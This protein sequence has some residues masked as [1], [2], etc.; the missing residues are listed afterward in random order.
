MSGPDLAELEEILRHSFAS[1][2]LLEQ[3]LT[4]ASATTGACTDNE[5]IEFL[6]DAVVTLAVNDYLYRHYTQC[7]EGRLT[8]IKS[9]VVSA[10]S[11]AARARELGLGRFAHMGRGMPSGGELS[12]AVLA[13]LFEAVVGALYLDAGFDRAMDF[14]LDQ[15]LDEIEAV[16]L[17]GGERNYKAVL[18]K[19]ASA[20][21]GE[22]PHYRLVSQAGPDHEKVFEVEVAIGERAFPS[23]RGRTKKEAEQRAAGHALAVLREER[24][25]EGE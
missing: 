10:T 3:A 22:L 9:S 17:T 12:D 24:P 20:A 6:G 13:N 23:A 11:L 7:E 19:L 5:R 8:E 1:P 16:S 21:F 4:H 18:Q 25:T 15:L 2:S 14:V